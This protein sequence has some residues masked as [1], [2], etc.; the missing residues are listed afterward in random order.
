[1]EGR[2]NREKD[3]IKGKGR[4]RKAC[5]LESK[6]KSVLLFLGYLFCYS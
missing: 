3:E 4:E 1:L 6:V 2:R 5:Y